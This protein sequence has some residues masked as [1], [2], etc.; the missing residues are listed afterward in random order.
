MNREE[1]V[2][3]VETLEDFDR[4]LARDGGETLE[5]PAWMAEEYGLFAEDVGSEDEIR[6]AG[7]DPDDRVEA[8]GR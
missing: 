5:V 2:V 3:R 4:V 6:T 1:R 8:G 7:R